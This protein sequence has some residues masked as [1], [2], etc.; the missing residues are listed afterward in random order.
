MQSEM[1]TAFRGVIRKVCASIQG[2][3]FTNFV[4]YERELLNL[5]TLQWDGRLSF[6]E[7]HDS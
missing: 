7:I 2:Q 1:Y 6:M 3:N 5:E 4:D